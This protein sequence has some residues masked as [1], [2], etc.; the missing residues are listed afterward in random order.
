MFREALIIL[1]ESRGCWTKTG[2]PETAEEISAQ[3]DLPLDKAR[4][5]CE[6][7]AAPEEGW[8]HTESWSRRDGGDN[9]GFGRERLPE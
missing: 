2:G 4:R 5:I 1:L 7:A 9:F 8:R 6:L 3:F